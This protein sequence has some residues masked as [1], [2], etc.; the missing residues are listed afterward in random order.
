MFDLRICCLL[1]GRKQTLSG[2]QKCSFLA[3]VLSFKI[4]KSAA[5]EKVTLFLMSSN[6]TGSKIP[7]WA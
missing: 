6:E 5:E 7:N 1:L 2:H 4:A 3:K